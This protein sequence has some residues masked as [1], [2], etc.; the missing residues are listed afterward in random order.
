MT[1]SVSLY[2]GKDSAPVGDGPPYLVEVVAQCGKVDFSQGRAAV[3]RH[4]SKVYTVFRFVPWNRAPVKLKPGKIID[5]PVAFRYG[6]NYKSQ[7][8]EF[9]RTEIRTGEDPLNLIRFA[10]A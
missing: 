2:Y 4:S 5:F 9:G 6:E 7:L 3:H 10:P 8:G 1:V